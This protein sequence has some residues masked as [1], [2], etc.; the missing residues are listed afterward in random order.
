M[1]RIDNPA[2]KDAY[3]Y[4][5]C[6]ADLCAPLLEADV[7]FAAFLPLSI[8]AWTKGEGCVTL[9]AL[10]PLEICQILDCSSLEELV[11]PVEKLLSDIMADAGEAVPAVPHAAARAKYSTEGAMEDQVSMRAAIP[12]R[13]DRKGSKVEEL[14]GTGVHDGS[15]G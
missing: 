5:I 1:S 12:Q 8:A 9:Q 13:I 11:K 10:S 14:A 7:R 6:Q 4:T 15:G 3:V 2:V